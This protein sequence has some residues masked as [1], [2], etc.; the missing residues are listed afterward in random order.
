MFPR[1]SEAARGFT[2]IELLVVIAVSGILMAAI[3]RFF[4]DSHKAYNLQEEISE[5]DQNAHYVVGRL[6]EILMQAGAH[7][8][9]KGWNV[10]V[11]PSQ[12]TNRFW[13]SSNPR[14]GVQTVQASITSRV[15]VPIDDE[16][17]FRKANRILVEYADKTRPIQAF[18]INRGHNV[19]GFDQG[20]K[21]VEDDIDT[22]VLSHPITLVAGDVFYAFVHEE[23]QLRGTSLLKGSMVMA[24]DIDSLR[25]SFLDS[26]W[27]PTLDWTAMSAARISV[28]ARTRTR[29]P[30]LPADGYRRITL[31]MDLR[32]RNRN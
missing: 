4:K 19:G 10:I 31:S 5:R 7:L 16:K 26:S 15:K 17:G 2:L 9:E 28:T 11:P 12:T 22:L 21:A 27:R 13:I 14:R 23:F 8:P 18:D 20:L 29:D 3:S 24:E 6:T 32:F 25:I 30:N 1:S